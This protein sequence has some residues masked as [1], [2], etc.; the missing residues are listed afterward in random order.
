M[1]MKTTIEPDKFYSH[2][3]PRYK[4]A[5]EKFITINGYEPTSLDFDNTDYLPSARTIQ[6]KY[7][8]LPQFRQ[9]I[10]LK[11]IDFSKD[12]TRS[13]KAKQSMEDCFKDENAL[14][15]DLLKQYG[16]DKVSSPVRVFARRGYTADIKLTMDGFSYLIDIFKPNS[17][18]SFKA[19]IAAKNKKYLL[20]EEM[21]YQTPIKFLY[22]CVNE[23]VMVPIPNN[24]IEILS[25][26]QF[27]EKFLK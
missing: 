23:D 2:D 19:C 24:P 14:F 22:V 5:V 12:A 4:A 18:H 1:Y 3:I 11:T 27:R 10:G 21:S 20:D 25:I 13:L 9:R 16:E 26:Q 15:Q 17:T 7:G 8:G 6:R